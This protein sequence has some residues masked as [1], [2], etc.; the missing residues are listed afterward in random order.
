MRRFLFSLLLLFSPLLFA[1][2]E[3]YFV[4]YFFGSEIS[5]HTIHAGIGGLYIKGHPI[6]LGNRLRIEY[7]RPNFLYFGLESFATRSFKGYKVSVDCSEW[8]HYPSDRFLGGGEYRLGYTL[9]KNRHRLIPFV[10][11]G[12]FFL[13]PVDSH[14]WGGFT[15]LL[16]YFTLGVRSLFGLTPKLSVGLN[17][18]LLNIR[19]G[20][21]TY[22]LQDGPLRGT[23]TC[24]GGEASLPLMWNVGHKLLPFL[25]IEP[26]L[27][28][29]DFQGLQ[30]TRGVRLQAGFTF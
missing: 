18:K 22:A 10:G 24:W 2:E 16:P 12:T 6:F 30:E 5:T 26:F 21:V 17:M 27:T 8:Y 3:S 1:E 11:A 15:Q 29:Y 28:K 19:N 9:T 4:E 20:I 13:L 7:V 23:C 25:Q 14:L